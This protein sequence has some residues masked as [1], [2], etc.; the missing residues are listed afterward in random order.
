MESV[1]NGITLKEVEERLRM[2]PEQALMLL[3]NAAHQARLSYSDHQA[4]EHAKITLAKSLGLVEDKPG[5][6]DGEKDEKV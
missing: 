6:D 2:N 3:V 5:E 1:K 4:I